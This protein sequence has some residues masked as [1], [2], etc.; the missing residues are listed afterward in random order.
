MHSGKTHALIHHMFIGSSVLHAMC[1]LYRKW[2]S[3]V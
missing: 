1:R 3:W 2:K